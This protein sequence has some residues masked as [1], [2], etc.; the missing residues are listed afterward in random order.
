M[1]HY[2][3]V[4]HVYEV[5]YSNLPLIHLTVAL[6]PSLLVFFL[7]PNSPLLLSGLISLFYFNLRIS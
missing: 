2:D 5:F 3:I 7:L 4:I 6:V 1:F